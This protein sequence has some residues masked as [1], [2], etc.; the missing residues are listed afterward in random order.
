MTEGEFKVEIENKIVEGKSLLKR[1]EN[2]QCLNPNV[3]PK[4]YDE[5]AKQE[6]IHELQDWEEDSLK[7]LEAY[8]INK[9]IGFTNSVP[10]LWQFDFKSFGK[11]NLKSNM[12]VLEDTL[13][14][15]LFTKTHNQQKYEMESSTTHENKPCEVFISH[16]EK[17]KKVARKLVD[18]LEFIGIKG[19]EKLFCSSAPGYEIPLDKNIFDY[20]REQFEKHEL[21]VI[22]LLSQNY[23]DRVITLNEMG[24]AWVT[25]TK[26]SSILIKGL[27][28]QEMKGVITP[29]RISIKVES[30]SARGLMD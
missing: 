15:S 25:K 24:A 17:D 20:L 8:N 10:N 21:Y 3:S 1:F 9:P 16:A 29:D 28:Y 2:L 5:T 11:T 6:L 4:R 7:I 13:N 14:R 30:D 23:Y 19:K 22:F 12:K 27:D 18:L 26:Y